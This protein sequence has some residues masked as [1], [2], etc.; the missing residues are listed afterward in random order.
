MCAAIVPGRPSL[1][2]LA[3][4]SGETTH[5]SGRSGWQ[6]PST[7]ERSDRST[8]RDRFMCGREDFRLSAAE[9]SMTRKPGATD[10]GSARCRRGRALRAG[11]RD[12]SIVAPE[13]EQARKEA[14]MIKRFSTLYVGHIELEHCG[15]A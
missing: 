11:L 3:K 2:R 8:E 15:L 4:R 10:R 9:R 12:A 7:T 1:N 6:W 5:G 13:G 14:R